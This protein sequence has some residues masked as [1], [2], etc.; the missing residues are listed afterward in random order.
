MLSNG[1]LEWWVKVLLYILPLE[2]L[3]LGTGRTFIKF[4]Y[5]TWW[6]QGESVCVDLHGFVSIYMQV[7]NSSAHILK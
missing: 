5:A 3:K 7:F 6:C 4:L 1:M 2:G